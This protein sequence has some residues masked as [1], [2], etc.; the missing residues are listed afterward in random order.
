MTPRSDQLR[1]IERT[2]LALGIVLGVWTLFV[3]GQ[4]WYYERMPVP[5]PDRG[6]A[7]DGRRLPGEEPS[8]PG[9]TSGRRVEPGSW[10][11]RLEAPTVQLT[12]TV[13]EGSDDGTLRR[14]AGHI[15]YTPLPGEDGNVGIAGHR[16]TTFR[17]V[18]HLEVGDPLRLTT[19]TR[20]LESK[21]S[22]TWVVDPE[23]VEVLDSNG[24]RAIT[25]VTCYPFSFVGNAPKRYIVRADL[26]AERERT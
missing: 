12:A 13:L 26:V 8:G 3:L 1:W 5:D 11:A 7:V 10:L 25:L 15:E 4:Q 21:V 16:D 23:D 9:G 14:A 19:A 20:I 17:A 24:G 22:R 6:G 2:L 18:R